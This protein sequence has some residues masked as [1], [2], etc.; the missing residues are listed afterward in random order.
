LVRCHWCA[1]GATSLSANLRISSRIVARVSSRPQSPTVAPCCARINST[2]RARRSTL[3]AAFSSRTGP[4]SARGDRLTREPDVGGT[5]DFALTHGNAALNLGEV[6]AD[7]DLDEQFLGLAETAAG[8]HPLGIS[9]ELA[10]RLHVG[11]EP[12]KTMGGALLAVEQ[13]VDHRLSTVTRLRT[14]AVASASNASTAWVA[15]CASA[16]S[17]G[18]ASGR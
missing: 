16:T 17:F 3:P 14:A 10:H 12:G 5:H 1:C 2:R 4:A 15:S 7:A 8:M 13:P 9:R 6:F 11:R 18:T